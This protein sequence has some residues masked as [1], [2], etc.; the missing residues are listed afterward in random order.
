MNIPVRFGG[1]CVSSLVFV[2]LLGY[3]FL[4]ACNGQ[5]EQVKCPCDFDL[6]VNMTPECWTDPFINPPL[7]R[8]P[9]GGP[10]CQLANNDPQTLPAIILEVRDDQG[11]ICVIADS[12]ATPPQP[13]AGTP[14][15]VIITGLTPEELKACQ[16]ELAAYVTALND[17]G[18]EVLGGPPY[19][20]GNV[21]C[22]Q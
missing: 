5:P 16:C 19:T 17:G 4:L 15:P 18:I 9:T 6:I 10:F 21:A 11:N 1:L 3:V 20:C 7:W 14:T 13:C 8:G 2:A 22:P 12:I